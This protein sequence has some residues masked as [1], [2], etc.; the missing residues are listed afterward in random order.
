MKTGVDKFNR[1]KCTFPVKKGPNGW[2]KG[3]FFIGGKTLQMSI[4]PRNA[5]DEDTLYLSF[6]ELE[7][8]DA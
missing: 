1:I 2:Y 3:Y 8:K 6:I 5:A 4:P 7:K